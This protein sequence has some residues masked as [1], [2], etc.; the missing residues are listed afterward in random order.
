LRNADIE[1]FDLAAEK[2]CWVGQHT[3]LM[4]SHGKSGIGS[5]CDTADAAV[6]AS[7]AT[8]NIDRD[9]ERTGKISRVEAFI[10]KAVG[11]DDATEADTEHSVKNNRGKR[12]FL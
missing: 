9:T 4:R 6:G 12:Q 2:A 5:E 3:D 1:H 7:D 8:G 10:K 11:F